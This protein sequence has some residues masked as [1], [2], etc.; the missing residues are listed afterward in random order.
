MFRAGPKITVKL[1]HPKQK[2]IEL[3]NPK[4]FCKCRLPKKSQSRTS[5]HQKTPVNQIES[6]RDKSDDELFIYYIAGYRELYEQV[7]DTNY[8]RV[9]D[10]YVT[11]ISN[12]TANKLESL[13][14]KLQFGKIPSILIIESGSVFSVLTS[15]GPK[16]NKRLI[17][18]QI[19]TPNLWI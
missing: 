8:D 1:A 18:I 17:K 4:P 14:A 16:T 15:C 11:A 13:N 3:R 2:N 5:P 9:S 19:P 6:T 7:Y 12:G 10:D